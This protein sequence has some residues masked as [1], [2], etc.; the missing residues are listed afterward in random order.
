MVFILHPCKGA[1]SNPMSRMPWADSSS[2]GGMPVFYWE[3]FQSPNH[4]HGAVLCR[5]GEMHDLHRLIGMFLQ[6][7]IEENYEAADQLDAVNPIFCIVCG[8]SETSRV[9][10]KSGSGAHYRCL[11]C[12][13]YFIINYCQKCMNRIWKHGAFW[14]YHDTHPESDYNMKCPRCNAYYEEK[15]EQGEY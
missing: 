7:S 8:G 9:T 4:M 5:P 13:H 6:Y 10:G 3:D 1:V 14:S 2:Y 12:N 15:V 11:C